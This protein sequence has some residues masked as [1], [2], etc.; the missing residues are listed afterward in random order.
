MSRDA[1][2]GVGE[3]L[4]HVLDVELTRET[5]AL[6]VRLGCDDELDRLRVR[7][8]R[9]VLH[10]LNDTR[11]F[12]H[13]SNTSTRTRTNQTKQDQWDELEDFLSEEA[14]H[15]LAEQQQ[16]QQQAAPSSAGSSRR[17]G[18]RYEEEKDEESR[19]STGASGGATPARALLSEVSV[20]FLPQIGY[21]AA[22][23]ADE[24]V[25]IEG[26]PTFRFVFAQGAYFFYK[27]PCVVVV[28]VGERV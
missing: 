1:L 28:V 12:I 21:L 4:A 6:A 9:T 15:L 18:S 14:R 11:G 3:A 20:Q 19:G 13:S 27:T 7:N 26:D 24:R 22:V 2:C 16:Q 23:S 17:R 8:V 25:A 5:K 10:P